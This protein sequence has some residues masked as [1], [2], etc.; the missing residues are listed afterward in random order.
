DGNT[1][2]NNGVGINVEGEP[3]VGNALLGNQV[4][5]NSSLGIDLLPFGVAANDG[6]TDA[7]VGPN[8]LQNF[9]VIAQVLADGGTTTIDYDLD[10]AAGDYRVEFFSVT[11]P[12]ATGNGEGH[13]FLGAQDATV[14]AGCGET[15]QLVLPTQLATTLSVTATATRI[16]AG[17]ASGFGGTSEFSAALGVTLAVGTIGD[18]VFNDRNGD[19][20]QDAGEGGLESVTLF[21]D[22]NGND[23]LDAGEQ[24]ATTDAS[25][26]YDLTDI[27]A[28]TYTVKVDTTTVPEGFVLTTG[29]DPQT[30]VLASQ[31]DFNDADFGFRFECAPGFFLDPDDPMNCLP[32]PPGTFVAMAGATEAEPC[33]PGTFQPLEGQ[34]SCAPAPAGRFVAIERATEAEVCALGTY[35]P[36]EGQTS[37]LDADPG[38]FVPA[39]GAIAQLP[40]ELGTFQ[41]EAGQSMCLP[42]PV[43]SYVDMEE[44]TSATSCPAGTTTDGEGA[45]SASD[46]VAITAQTFLVTKT[47]DTN[48][49]TCDAD[50]SLREAI[51]AADANVAAAADTI[52]FSPAM[53]GTIALGGSHLVL[54]TDVVIEGP[55]ATVL[56]VSGNGTSRVFETTASVE[57]RDLTI[58]GGLVQ[59]PP[60]DPGATQDGGGIYNSGTLTLSRCVVSENA[61]DGSGGGINNAGGTLVLREC[62]ITEND[63]EGIAQFDGATLTVSN[64][65]ISNNAG[66][67]IN[68]NGFVDVTRSTFHGN[69]G[70]GIAA[71][72]SSS[73]SSEDVI[74]S[75][76]TFSGNV[77]GIG[78]SSGG[79]ARVTNSTFRDNGTTSISLFIASELTIGN[80]I[81][82]TGDTGTSFSAAGSTINSLGTNI[83]GDACGLTGTGDLTETN[84]LLDVL[85]DNGGPTLTHALLPGSP[86]IDIGGTCGPTD[87]RGFDAPII[88]LA[89]NSTA[90]C[91]AG[92]LE[93][94]ILDAEPPT[95]VIA[96]TL[97]DPTATQ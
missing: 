17:Q 12:D 62:M 76:S 34:T 96:T 11:T 46:C 85:G 79:R 13:S 67:G 77:V 58:T 7:D 90:L 64:S 31:E 32:A 43:G 95:V 54:S 4:F 22:A 69:E 28:G 51:A 30:V 21:L 29:N 60:S 38:N 87:Q 59:A 73:A 1:I 50:C 93:T 8:G 86:A 48:D 5:D 78:L 83:C 20:V 55:G 33:V 82:D 26:A 68:S 74:V 44:A 63:A 75:Q 14:T 9:P 92:S 18:F 16:D 42:A 27:L 35:Q 36:L 6:C 71:P 45:T 66:D 56:A 47:D 49:G 39:E 40:C 23:E 65:T 91:D 10:T 94:E 61:A 88:G 57:I 72:G 41:P 19:G 52:T 3:A 80:S 25:G 89:I 70:S 15:F 84:P 2:A 24:S 37:C 97:D 81:I 53:T